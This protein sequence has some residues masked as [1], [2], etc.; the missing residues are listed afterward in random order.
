MKRLLV[1]AMV[2]GLVLG[3]GVSFASD[4]NTVT[5]TANVVGTCKFLSSTSTL[6]FGSLDPSSGSDVNASTTVQFWCTKNA[7]YSII[8]DNGS[9]EETGS[10]VHRMK[11]PGTNNYI[12]YTF[13]YTPTSGQGNGRTNPIDLKISGTV[14]FTDYQNA[15]AGDYSDTVVLTI[16]P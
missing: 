10:D 14:K 6:A 2:L 15:V 1:L 5:V 9:N 11:G 4:T 13:E 16:T 12:P 7:N 3:I 8:D